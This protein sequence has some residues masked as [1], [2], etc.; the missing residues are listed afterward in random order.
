LV[1]AEISARE[2]TNQQLRLK[3][4]NPAV[5]TDL[6]TSVISRHRI[7]D[8][9]APTLPRARRQAQPRLTAKLLLSAARDLNSDAIVDLAV[10]GASRAVRLANLGPSANIPSWARFP[11]A[12]SLQASARRRQPGG[13]QALRGV[14]TLRLGFA[15]A[16]DSQAAI[17]QLDL[18][19]ASITP[20][21]RANCT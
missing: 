14:P 7:D 20:N 6:G 17:I 11:C 13:G 2:R 21:V 12:G 19:D 5:L 16:T 1:A 3:A 9:T 8:A 10:R 15:R 4:A 18:S